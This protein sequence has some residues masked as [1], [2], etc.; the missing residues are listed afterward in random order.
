MVGVAQLQVGAVPQLVGVADCLLHM[1]HLSMSL[2]KSV[3]HSMVDEVL[4]LVSV[5]HL[6]VGKAPQL[7]GAVHWL[8]GVA[9]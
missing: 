5:P 9:Y 3:A 2:L 8:V 4:L 1:G 7:A 6:L